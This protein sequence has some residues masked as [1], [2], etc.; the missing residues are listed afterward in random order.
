MLKSI[1][2]SSHFWT[3]L[4]AALSPRH[5][6]TA[7]PFVSRCRGIRRSGNASCA[8]TFQPS[9]HSFIQLFELQCPH[10]A[11]IAFSNENASKQKIGVSVLIESEPRLHAGP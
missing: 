5:R 6:F 11:P 7:R 8:L 4:L 3:K 2:R 1:G 10:T 9:N